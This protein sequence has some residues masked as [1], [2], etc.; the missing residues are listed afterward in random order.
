M[1][2]FFLFSCGN[3]KGQRSVGQSLMMMM[4]MMM[5]CLLLLLFALFLGASSSNDDAFCPS[6]RMERRAI[7][8]GVKESTHIE[9][10]CLQSRGGDV[11]FIDKEHS[12]TS[13][14]LATYKGREDY[15]EKLLELSA[16]MNIKS[17]TGRTPLV[18]AAFYNR[19]KI[20]R[21]L[22]QQEDCN[23]NIQDHDGQS[24][25]PYLIR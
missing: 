23:C 12:W 9:I 24:I 22:L 2:Y 13:L 3:F 8:D 14:H 4:M 1:M 10:K 17:R 21:M 11:N 5:M 19:I 16:D 7:Y 18:K 6:G 25:C 15:V 20:T